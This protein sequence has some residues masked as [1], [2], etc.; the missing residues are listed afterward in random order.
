MASFATVPAHAD[1]PPGSGTSA[2]DSTHQHDSQST[3]D[4][5]G[6]STSGEHDTDNDAPGK[7]KKGTKRRKGAPANDGA[8]LPDPPLRTFGFVLSVDDSIK[9]EIG[10]LCHDERRAAGK[11]K[12][13]EPG[14]TVSTS[15]TNPPIDVARA[16]PGE[17][18]P[19][20]QVLP[21]SL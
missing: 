15:V 4:Q 1:P 18:P 11:D 20:H 21:P 16:P 10:H 12:S 8:S 13:S 9:R 7:K 14:S 3:A 19:F 17:Y 2:G 6:N 5:L